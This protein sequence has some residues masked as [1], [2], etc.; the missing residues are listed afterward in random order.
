MRFIRNTAPLLVALAL[1][2][3]AAGATPLT[4]SSSITDGQSLSGSLRWTASTS[5]SSISTVEF[6]IDN[7]RK[8]TERTAP[9]V[10]GGDQGTLDTTQLTNGNH[11]FSVTATASDGT[12]ASVT[13]TATTKN[14]PVNKARPSITGSTRDGD[15]LRFNRGTWTGPEP[16]DY[17]YSW[18]RCDAGGNGCAAISGATGT[19]YQ[20]KTAD[21]G[22]RIRITVT[23]SNS[24]G[25]V[26]ATSDASAPIAGRGSAPA[27]TAAP[28]ISGVARDGAVLR[29]STGGWRNAPTGYKY[30][31]LRC[32]SNGA[33]CG[34]IS[35][36]NSSR[37][38]ITS[39]DVGHR[40]RVNVTASNAFGAAVATSNAT[41][42]VGA[43]TTAPAN[44]VLPSIAGAT[45]EGSKLDVNNGGW[46]GTQPISLGY[47]WR[48]CDS[49]GNACV[50]IPGAAA[51]SYVL[52][53][54]DVGHTLRVA[55]TARNSRGAATATSGQTAVVTAAKPGAQ[56]LDVAQVAL[57]NRLVI[58]RV[59][60]S[61]SPVRSRLAPIVA[62]FHVSDSRGFSIAGVPVLA[63][64]LPYGWVRSAPEA[65]TD[66]SGW[67]TVV[68]RAGGS[69]PRR[70][71]LVVF[72][73]ARKPGESLLAGVST[74]R[75]VQ[76]LIRR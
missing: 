7:V 32:D 64:G 50:D 4:V 65:M 36:A 55:L 13:A 62:R 40:L 30:Q 25:A 57:P 47:A 51:S 26:P 35:G 69:F 31:W 54:A 43:T 76:V 29:T 66:G 72:V 67:A 60:F 41:S 74:R 37:Y 48:R 49:G 52:T 61:P 15:V 46:S 17:A 58:D 18:L 10:Y 34:A 53:S 42:T 6:F 1:V 9:Y 70:G 14:P 21:V 5:T 45:K 73:R 11:V 39:A 59:R 8:S 12:K 75:L 33:N 3:G 22:H 56:T 63:L 16:I 44:T 28:Q 38:T 2:A 27:S 23:A 19:A 68:L 24:A 20:L 71:S